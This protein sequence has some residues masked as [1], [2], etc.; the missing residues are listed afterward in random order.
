MNGPHYAISDEVFRRFPD[1]LRGVV[2][3]HEVTNGPSPDAIVR[4]LRDVEE[5]VRSRLTLDQ[6]AEEPRIRSWREAYRAFG[7]KP[8]EFR[9]S[10]EALA[11]RALRNEPLPS[12]NALVDIG[13]VVSLRHLL[14]VGGH[15]IDVLTGDIAL[16]L[17]TGQEEFTPF[18]SEQMEHPLP[19]EVIFVEGNTVLTRRWTWRQA[20]PTL[21]LLTTR[22]IEFNVDGL[23]PVS[24]PEVEQVCEEVVDLV[25]RF[26][27]GRGRYEVLSQNNCR[28]SLRT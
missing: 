17:A 26:C 6:I 3:A 14:P 24:R 7:A 1:Y 9:S 21:T 23:P 20:N 27:G 10:V 15:A 13:N 28:I 5:S 11:R 19:G 18:G 22:A 25:G 8:S 16:R 2:I 4:M 12:F